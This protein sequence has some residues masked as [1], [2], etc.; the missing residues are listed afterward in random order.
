MLREVRDDDLPILFAHQADPEAAALAAFPSRDRAAFDEHWTW[1][2][3]DT[4]VVL[5]TIEVDGAVAGSIG[6]F[7]QDARRM[8]GYWIGREHWG[9]GIASAAL[10]EFLTVVDERPLFAIVA[11]HNAAS[12]RVLEKC[13]FEPA[14]EPRPGAAG[15]VEVEFALT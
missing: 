10:A 1:T 4:S 5:R 2:R 3:M 7:L 6:S 8:V 12:Q 9:R 15:V 11:A 14:G 13:G